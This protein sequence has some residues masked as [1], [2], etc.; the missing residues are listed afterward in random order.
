MLR[1]RRSPKSVGAPADTPKRRRA[2]TLSCFRTITL[3]GLPSRYP[4]NSVRIFAKAVFQLKPGVWQGPVQSGYGWHLVFV[5]AIEPSRVRPSRKSSPRQ[6]RMAGSEASRDQTCRFR[7]DACTL[8]G[9]CCPPSTSSTGEVCRRCRSPPPMWCR[10]E[11]GF[12][13]LA[14]ACNRRW[15]VCSS[16]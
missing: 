13:P 12:D 8:H 15:P 14:G 5:D 6:I 3:N 2:P 16:H 1:R 11:C 4:R 10:N 9:C 7:R